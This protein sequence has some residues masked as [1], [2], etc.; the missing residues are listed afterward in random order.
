MFQHILLAVDGSEHGMLAA[1]AAGEIAK[2]FDSKLTFLT[3][4]DPP[5]VY[6]VTPLDTM[7][8]F[9]EK[10]ITIGEEAQEAVERNTGK[11]LE[12]S[13][14][15]YNSLRAIGHPA[16]QIIQTAKQE[17]VDLI[18]MGSRGLGGWQS[19]FLGSISDSVLHHA[20]CPVLI[21]R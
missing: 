2:K 16:D 20:H 12:E 15:P 21:I 17:N 9:P 3:V 8:D 13:G 5:Q 10:L 19:L 4:F 14:I 1:K 7:L 11:V 18:V 6:P